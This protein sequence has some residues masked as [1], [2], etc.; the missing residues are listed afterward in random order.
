MER[1]VN[2]NK[3]I[4]NLIDFKCFFFLGKRS[5]TTRNQS[6]ESKRN[7]NFWRFII[8]KGKSGKLNRINIIKYYNAQI[9]A[10]NKSIKR[11]PWSTC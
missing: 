2:L 5:S 7:Y 3:N 11:E 4:G 8:T 9:L 1:E 6:T 10:K